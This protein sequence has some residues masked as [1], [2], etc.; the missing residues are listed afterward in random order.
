LLAERRGH[1]RH[2]VHN[3]RLITQE[4]AHTDGT[5][6][7]FVESANANFQAFANQDASLR[8]ALGLLPGTLTTT[9]D[10]L[11]KADSL[12]KELGPTAQALRPTARALGPALR[13]V[14]PFLRD[15][16]PVIKNSLRPFSRIARPT[17]R[18]LRPTA[19]DLAAATPRLARTFKVV[20]DLLNTFAYNPPGKEEGYLFWQSWLNHSGA[21]V[22]GT[23]DA[24]GPIRRGLVLVSC[25]GLGVLDQIASANPQL[26][27]LIDLLSAPQQSEICPQATPPTGA[28]GPT[29]VLPEIPPITTP[30]VPLP[31]KAA[32]HK[33]SSRAAASLPPLS[34]AVQ[35]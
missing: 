12:A 29:Q 20:N 15:T 17:V 26:K 14:R 11:R 32:P 22:F 18:D 34:K 10:S 21:T 30:D 25:D 27:V 4:L 19:H 33:A 8:A 35:P 5:L 7:R 6:G 28:T 1:V 23:Q 2:V 31:R 9:R 16:T 24:H 13:D 3:F